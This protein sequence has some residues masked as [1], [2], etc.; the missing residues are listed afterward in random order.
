MADALY[1]GADPEFFSPQPVEKEVDVFFYGYG[2]KFRRDWM[3]TLVGEPS[4]IAIELDFSLGGPRFQRDTGNARLL[5]DIPFNVCA[6]AISAARVNLNITR[7][8][9]AVVRGSSTAR[10]FELA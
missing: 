3:E 5:G 9:H 6:R 8:P 10:L 7:R 1:W 2:D 4:R